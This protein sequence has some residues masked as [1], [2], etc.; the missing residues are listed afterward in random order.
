MKLLR[1]KSLFFSWSLQGGSKVYHPSP[2]LQSVPR[3][4][5]REKDPKLSHFVQDILKVPPVQPVCIVKY[6]NVTLSVRREHFLE[7]IKVVNNLFGG[8]NILI[9]VVFSSLQRE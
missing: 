4:T 6:I 8:A 9:P 5:C 1:A 2:V 3:Q 7:S